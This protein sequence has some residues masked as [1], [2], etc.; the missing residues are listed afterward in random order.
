MNYEELLR[1]AL[2]EGISISTLASR[3][4]LL[5]MAGS[6]SEEIRADLAKVLA[7][8]DAFEL[9]REL[10]L[11]LARDEDDL[12]RLEAIDSLCG[13][14]GEETEKV[15]C[16]ALNDG[17]ELIRMYAA[18]GIGEVSAQDGEAILRAALKTETSP[19]ARLGMWEGLYRLGFQEGL[20]RMMALYETEDYRLQ[21]AVLHGLAGI[22]DRENQAE[23]RAFADRV[24]SPELSAAIADGVKDLRKALAALDRVIKPLEPGEA[25][26]FQL[27]K[28]G[29]FEVICETLLEKSAEYFNLKEPDENGS[30]HML[31]IDWEQET[32]TLTCVAMGDEDMFR[33]VDFDKL[34]EMGVGKTAS[35]YTQAYWKSVSMDEI[36]LKQ[37]H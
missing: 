19:H 23:L 24:D 20:G 17:D 8:D 35:V 22:A 29:V 15:F 12:V 27:D 13:F 34:R 37:S 26:V 31:N 18:A 32:G 36:E 9:S 4:D 6:E 14:P 5:G 28:D 7:Q 21:C 1:T 3:E 25:R 10:L 2:S 30:D 33:K 11:R 16:D